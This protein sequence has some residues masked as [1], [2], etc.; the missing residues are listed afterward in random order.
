MDFEGGMDAER[1]AF[2]S[3]RWSMRTRHLFP[4]EA[5]AFVPLTRNFG[6]TGQP[7]T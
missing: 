4:R 2:A 5:P 3:A 7:N 6:A 1:P